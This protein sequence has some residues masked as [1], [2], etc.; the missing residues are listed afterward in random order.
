METLYK[1]SKYNIVIDES[2]TSVTIYNTY[3][4][5]HTELSKA[6]Y[7]E[8]VNNQSI[9]LGDY[10]V[11]LA[12][13]GFIVPVAL[14]ETEKMKSDI[15]RA[16]HQRE[17]LDFI[18]AVT[19]RCNYRCYYCFESEYLCNEDM[20]IETMD[21]VI[22]F[23][24]NKCE[25]YTELKIVSLQWFG[26]EPTLNIPAIRYITD[27]LRDYLN[28][29]NIVI[30]GHITTNGRQFTP[31]VI[32]ELISKYYLKSA[33]ITLDGMA[34]EY[35]KIKGCREEDFY[36]VINNIKYAQDKIQVQIRLNLG[37]NIESLKQLVTLIAKENMKVIIHYYHVWDTS[38]TP[39][40]YKLAYGNFA[41]KS[42]EF[43]EFIDEND[44][45]HLFPSRAVCKRRTLAC[46]A[47]ADFQFSIGI[48]GRLYKC[49]E[50]I[51]V[52]K[53]SIGNIIDGITNPAVNDLFIE[54]KLKEDCYECSYLPVCIGKCTMEQLA[55]QKGVNCGAVKR[56]LN[57]Q[58]K[59][60]ML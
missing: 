27:N 9:D 28:S 44:F 8:L 53:Y 47:N 46:Q 50:K 20:S 26:G 36:E 22:K 12:Q 11:Y 23:I 52:D 40:N 43:E 60:S 42:E 54:N 32:D 1:Y 3:S 34:T 10:P 7:A 21:N 5:Q 4:S 15:Y 51:S 33:Q 39:D 58:I 29:H 48:D 2:E 56:L 6:D 59:R 13:Q 38:M 16:A 25:E 49:I 57:G 24:K 55:E 35:A 14:D 31:T 45:G 17:K 30:R 18:I 37:N 41:D 19:Q